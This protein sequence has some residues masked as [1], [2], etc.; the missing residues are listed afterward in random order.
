MAC[1][2]CYKCKFPLGDN[3]LTTFTFLR[4]NHR[5]HNSC[6]LGIYTC[7]CIKPIKTTMSP[8]FEDQLSFLWDGAWRQI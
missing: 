1:E 5:I 3:L 7:P 8:H 6:T 4:C 2:L